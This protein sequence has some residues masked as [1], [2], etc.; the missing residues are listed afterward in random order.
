MVK[1]RETVV[2]WNM[3]CNFVERVVVGLVTP[4]RLLIRLRPQA[5]VFYC[6]DTFGPDTCLGL[7]HGGPS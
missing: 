2:G 5:C 4:V 6:R 1:L 7:G 3:L